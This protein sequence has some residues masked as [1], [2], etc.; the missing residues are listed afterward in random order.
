VLAMSLDSTTQGSEIADLAE[1]RAI[2]RARK[3]DVGAFE[4]LYRK[5]APRVFGL[6]LRMTSDRAL[7]EELT[8]ETFVRVWEKL[9]LFQGDRSMAPWILTVASRVVI[10][11]FRG[12][13]RRS[14]RETAVAELDTIGAAAVTAGRPGTA[15]DLERA[16][17]LLPPGA[18]QVFVLHDVQGYR[19][20]EIAELLGVAVGTTKAQLHR[21]RR[22][23]REA[24]A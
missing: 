10:S 20:D 18:R 4:T 7:A 11:Q 8:Q 17:G 21:A 13:R 3:G 2:R 16:L 24:L 12:R 22:M 19:H 23:L 6:C 15:L 5:H 9:H 1:I 14:E